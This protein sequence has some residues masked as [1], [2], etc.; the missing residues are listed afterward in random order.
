MSPSDI[1]HEGVI[2]KVDRSTTTVEILSK[3]ACSSCHAA[4]LCTSMDA[5]KKDVEV[6]TDP[7]ARYE[8]GQKVKVVLRR[9]LGN[10][11]VLLAYVIP[12]L[13]MLLLVVTLSFT[14]MSELL[15]GAVGIGGVALWYGVLYLLRDRISRG[16]VFRIEK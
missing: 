8:V 12:L 16:Y 9:D 13:V 2:K 14:A 6:P 7:S 3:S 4:S 10:R 15:V 5:V 1:S 11:A